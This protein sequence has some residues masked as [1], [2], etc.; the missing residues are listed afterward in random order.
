M[1]SANETD[2]E[3]G[4][5]GGGQEQ[6][7]GRLTDVLQQAAGAEYDTPEVQVNPQKVLSLFA[8]AQHSSDVASEKQLRPHEALNDA[9]LVN[10][11]TKRGHELL[12]MQARSN[13]SCGPHAMEAG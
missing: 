3:G 6:E 8:E 2:G 12:N 7:V 5:G 1:A 10:G 11:P 9:A 4:G 13:A